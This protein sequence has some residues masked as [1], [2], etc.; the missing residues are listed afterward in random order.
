MENNTSCTL[1]G[2]LKVSSDV[3]VRIAEAAIAE[4]EGV[5]VCSA[6]GKLSVLGGAPL[7]QKV[8]APTKVR[9]NGDS[10]VIEVSVITD[11]GFKAYEVAR[12]LQEHIKSAVQSMTGITVSKVNI[13]IVGVKGK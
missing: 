4:T 9:M 10:A 2:S 7:S 1:P 12:A 6:G 5:A 3:I 8:I 13:K 11:I